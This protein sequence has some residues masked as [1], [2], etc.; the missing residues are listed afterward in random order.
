ML[1]EDH[2]GGGMK[3]GVNVAKAKLQETLETNLKKHLE[4]YAESMKGWHEKLTAQLEAS[5][6]YARKALSKARAGDAEAKW[7]K[8]IATA[9]FVPHDWHD[10]PV[11]YAR[12]YE[13][14]IEMLKLSTDENIGLSRT[15][16]QQL[17]QDKWEWSDRHLFSN[18]K[19]SGI[20]TL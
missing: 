19:Y 2:R 7:M 9:K 13:D 10:E 4:E 3:L 1:D 8:D 14:A 20:G 6:E 11:S 18:R 12:H 15:L 5:I 16:F 17:V